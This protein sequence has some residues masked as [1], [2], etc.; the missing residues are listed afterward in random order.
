MT[1][2]S[3]DL[4][5]PEG[6]SA[7]NDAVASL[8]R[9]DRHAEAEAILAD[10]FATVPSEFSALALSLPAEAISITGWEAFNTKIEAVSLGGKPVTAVG[11][12]I[13]DQG[14]AT[15]EGGVANSSSNRATTR[16]RA[17]SASPR[18]PGKACWRRAAAPARR[19]GWDASP[20]PTPAS[21]SRVSRRFATLCCSG[22]SACG[23]I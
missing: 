3:I 4:M 21:P 23:P 18:R 19:R 12:D 16:T 8:I 2:L 22:P 17:G 15:D 7:F 9:S 1:D 11:I 20:M 6:R 5:A 14:D 13:T 10:H